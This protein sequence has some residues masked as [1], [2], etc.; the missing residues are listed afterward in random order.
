MNE[1]AVS[2]DQVTINRADLHSLLDLSRVMLGVED[3]EEARALVAR[4]GARMEE[5]P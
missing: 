3:V 4:L 1:L 5:N 2:H